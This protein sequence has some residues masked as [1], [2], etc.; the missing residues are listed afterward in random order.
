MPAARTA[1]WLVPV[2]LS[3]GLLSAHAAGPQPPH[4]ESSKPRAAVDA[5]VRCVDDSVLKLKLLDD[6]LELVTKHGVLLIPVAEVRRIDFAHRVPADVAEKALVT[7]GKLNHSD[8][9]VREAA[10]AE[11]K[12]LRER[13]YPYVLKAVKNDDPEIARRAD[14]VAKFIQA[15]VP[16]GQLDGRDTDV[17]HTDD[18]RITGRL[19]AEVLRVSTAQFG[20]QPLRLADARTLRVGSLPVADDAASASPAPATLAAYQQ[21]FGKELT[22]AVTGATLAPGANVGVWGTDLYTL[23]SQVAAAAVHAGLAKPGETVAVKVR[24]VASPPQFVAS[25]RHG[26]S[27]APYG[28]YPAGAF[29]FVRK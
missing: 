19:S 27:S 29:E 15:K 1:V 18:S 22:L 20:D 10:T 26:V 21:Q 2:A 13:A 23:D 9:H 25:A 17:V 8:F 28:N 5:E 6:K 3:V 7:I 14:E 11:L 16:A 24:I 4:S 12:G